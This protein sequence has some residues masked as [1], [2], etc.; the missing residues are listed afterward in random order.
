MAAHGVALEKAA[1]FLARPPVRQ[2]HHESLHEEFKRRI[3]TQTAL[4]CAEAAATIWALLRQDKTLCAIWTVGKVSP[5][6]LPISQL[7]S[8]HNR[9]VS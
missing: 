8:P 6:N 2:A 4:P 7:T 5:K 9:L 1:G 3:K